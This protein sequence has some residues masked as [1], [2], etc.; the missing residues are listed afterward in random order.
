MAIWQFSVALIPREWTEYDGNGPEM[1]HDGEGYHDTPSAWKNNQPIVNLVELISRVL[2]PAESWS[3]S[4]M[5]WGDERGNDIQV[6]YEGDNVESVT[7]RIDTRE[8]TA[9]LCFRII[10]LARALDCYLFLPAA[11]SIIA[12]DVAGLSTAV[13]TSRGARFAAAPREF[14]EQLGRAPFNER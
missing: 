14:I 13:Q 2:P 3:D 5:T 10:E 7:I 6:S 4:L 9:H 1:L 12:S 8:D 11:R